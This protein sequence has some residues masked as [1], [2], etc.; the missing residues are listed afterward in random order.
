MMTGVVRTFASESRLIEWLK[1]RNYDCGSPEDF[2]EWFNDFFEAGNEIEVHG[3]SYGYLDCIE[4][5]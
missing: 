3:E 2:S 4:L 1:D 5:I